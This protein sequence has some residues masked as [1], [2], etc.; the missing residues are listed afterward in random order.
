MSK[1]TK[2]TRFKMFVTFFHTQVYD[3]GNKN[4]LAAKWHLLVSNMSALYKILTPEQCLSIAGFIVQT[5]MSG[6]NMIRYSKFTLLLGLYRSQ[7]YKTF[8]CSTQLSIRFKLLI[9]SGIAQHNF[10]FRSRSQ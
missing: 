10:N 1:N 2:F 6:D 9:N 8:F 7:G 3:V 5:A 4:Y